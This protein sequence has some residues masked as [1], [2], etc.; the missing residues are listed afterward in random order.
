MTTTASPPSS[1]SPPIRPACPASPTSRSPRWASTSSTPKFLFEQLRR[2]ADDAGFEPRFRQGHHPVPRQAR[3]GG[4]APL[5]RSLRP[6][7]ERGRGLL[8][9]RRHGRRL[10]G[11]QYRPDRRRAPSSTSTIAAGRSGPMR[12]SPPP[13]KFVHDDRRPARLG[14]LVAGL[15]RLHRLG[16]VDPPQPAVHRRARRTAFAMLDEA[17]VLPYCHIGRGARLRKVVIDRGVSIPE[18]LVVGDDPGARRRALPPHRQG[19]L[20]DHQADDRP[21]R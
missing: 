2:D 17:V 19:R 20:P 5:R 3:Q 4:G 6:L 9:R 14:D 18:G 16:R 10:L 12:R 11:G 15:G 8:A 21:A 13:A 7:A 1:R